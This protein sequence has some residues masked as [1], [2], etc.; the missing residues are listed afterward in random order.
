MK[1]VK[2]YILV[3]CLLLSVFF[4]YAKN[5]TTKTELF[6]WDWTNETLSLYITWAVP[7]NSYNFNVKIKNLSDVSVSVNVWF[8][9][10]TIT[11]DSYKSKACLHEW[12]NTKIWQ[13]ISGPSSFSIWAKSS[14][15]KNYTISLPNNYSFSGE[16]NAC[17]THYPLSN[18]DGWVFSMSARRANFL[19]I[20][21]SPSSIIDTVAPTITSISPVNSQ[22]NISTNANIVVVFSEAMYKPSVQS[23][24]QIIPSVGAL[25]FSWNGNILTISHSNL[26]ANSTT[27]NFKINTWAK[28][29]AGN[30]LIS[31][32]SSVFTTQAVS[33]PGWWGGWGWWGGGG[34]FYSPDKPTI[35]NCPD[36]DY[37]GDFYDGDCWSN[38]EAENNLD[39][40]PQISNNL[41]KIQN[42]TYSEE[43]NQAYIYACNVGITTMPSIQ[44]ADMMWPLIRKHLAKMISEFSIKVLWNK[45]DT[46]KVCN[47]NDMWNETKEMQYYAKLSCQ[48]YLM[49]LR[50][51]WVTPMEYFDPNEVVTRAQF[52]TVLSR[53]LWQTQ[54]AAG[55][56]EAYYSRH[57]EALRTNSIMTQIYG[58]WPYINELRGWVMLMLMRVNENK[59][60]DQSI[61]DSGKIIKWWVAAL[62]DE[63]SINV[64][65]QWFTWNIYYTDVDFVPIRWIIN[66]ENISKITVT[67]F[68]SK[69]VWLYNNYS[70]QKFK[71]WDKN[72]VFYAY[73]WY[74]TLTLNDVNRYQFNFFDKEGKL[75]FTRTVFVDH[76][77]VKNR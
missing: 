6:F 60:A 67:H 42:S 53:L 33:N 39:E 10:G 1:F 63:W 56:N 70:L 19:D 45:P 47:F 46:N 59:L 65:L 18:E 75:I 16:I 77:Y 2:F 28:D 61:L 30:G 17:L 36:W 34:W 23:A 12:Y 20:Y 71:P 24:I 51:D 3:L 74:N 9:D 72:F 44:Q 22:S 66:S 8:V 50:P 73:K 7:G 43:L 52:G 25:W 21:V 5:E 14:V 11:A 49:W 26:F 13:H 35:D 38:K 32:F 29:L 62:L 31:I 4:V 40:K 41:C 68:D 76:H 55:I 27:Y 64:I 69:W 58:Q 54:Y 37:S 57:L 15:I 48:L